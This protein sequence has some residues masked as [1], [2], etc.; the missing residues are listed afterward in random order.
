MGALDDLM[1]LT[2]TKPVANAGTPT[3]DPKE[4][5][6]QMFIQAEKDA[7]TQ[8]VKEDRGFFDKVLD[9]WASLFDAAA[10]KVER[11]FQN[12][13]EDMGI[14]DWKK[15]QAFQDDVATNPRYSQE[16][17]QRKEQDL[18]RSGVINDEYYA[19]IRR[20][21]NTLLNAE[22]PD[23]VLEGK[24]RKD[25]TA[26]LSI[27]Y[28]QTQDPNVVRILNQ[29]I[30]TQTDT[31]MNYYR[32]IAES[33]D[34]LEKTLLFQELSAFMEKG[35]T[36]MREYADNVVKT[37]DNV[38]AYNT[39]A[40][41]HEEFLRDMDAWN[42]KLTTSSRWAGVKWSV[43]GLFDSDFNLADDIG[44]IWWAGTGLISMATGLIGGLAHQTKRNVFGSYN[45]GMEELRLDYIEKPTD[46][47]TTTLAGKMG[48]WIGEIWD[49][50]DTLL[51][52]VIPIFAASKIW[53]LTKTENAA[54]LIEGTSKASKALGYTKYF[55]T[56]M[57][58]DAVIFDNAFQ[59]FQKRGT[60]QDE[61]TTNFWTNAVFNAGIAVV[62]GK[63]V[64]KMA[65]EYEAILKT[66]QYDAR[67][68]G[69][70]D[71]IVR[72][73]NAGEVNFAENTIYGTIKDMSEGIEPVKATITLTSKWKENYEKIL[74]SA[75]RTLANLQKGVLTD[76]GFAAQ[77]IIQQA[78]DP[79]TRK[80]KQSEDILEARKYLTEQTVKEVTVNKATNGIKSLAQMKNTP[81]TE[82]LLRQALWLL[83]ESAKALDN[84]P[85]AFTKQVEESILTKIKNMKGGDSS[86]SF[87][88]VEEIYAARLG[89][90]LVDVI[91]VTDSNTVASAFWKDIIPI[92]QI[93]PSIPYKTLMSY[94]EL[95]QKISFEPIQSTYKEFMD[96][97]FKK[98][99][100]VRLNTLLPGWETYDFMSWFTTRLIKTFGNKDTGEINMAR[101]AESVRN[102]NGRQ[103]GFTAADLDALKL[104]HLPMLFEHFQK[105]KLAN[106]SRDVSDEK[107]FTSHPFFRLFEKTDDGTFNAKVNIADYRDIETALGV[108]FQKMTRADIKDLSAMKYVL[109]DEKFKDGIIKFFAEVAWAIA[110][111]DRKH[112]W[113][114]SQ[115]LFIDPIK[116][117]Q[118]E[119]LYI[120]N[121]EDG[122][123]ILKMYV[124]KIIKKVPQLE[125]AYY[126]TWLR[127]LPERPFAMQKDYT[128]YAREFS[129]HIDE[130]LKSAEVPLSAD[131]IKVKNNL[132]AKAMD[133]IV[134][135]N[136]IDYETALHA[137]HRSAISSDVKRF[138]ELLLKLELALP[139]ERVTLQ[140]EVDILKKSIR[141][142]SKLV[143]GKWV[144]RDNVRL[145]LD[146]LRSNPAKHTAVFADIVKSEDVA[147]SIRAILSSTDALS[148]ENAR[149]NLRIALMSTDLNHNDFVNIQELL[150][151]PK[152]I[153]GDRV[154]YLK[155]IQK[156]QDGNLE[157]AVMYKDVLLSNYLSAGV[158]AIEEASAIV[159]ALPKKETLNLI[160]K[161]KQAK[162]FADSKR[163]KAERAMPKA[164]PESSTQLDA[165]YKSQPGLFSKE[166]LSDIESIPAKSII[167]VGRESDDSIDLIRKQKI[168]GSSDTSFK[169]LFDLKVMF[170]EAESRYGARSGNRTKIN[171]YYKKFVER[172]GRIY[173]TDNALKSYAETLARKP[174][175]VAKDTEWL[176]KAM[177]NIRVD[178]HPLL[179]RLPGSIHLSKNKEGVSLALT[180]IESV[181]I[182]KTLE[183]TNIISDDSKK[184]LSGLIP[185]MQKHLGLESIQFPI[186]ALRAKNILEEVFEGTNLWTMF[187]SMSK[188][189]NKLKGQ[190][191]DIMKY[192]KGPDFK[193]AYSE[194]VRKTTALINK[195]GA[196]LLKDAPWVT[197]SFLLSEQEYLDMSRV[198]LLSKDLNISRAQ[199]Y[200]HFA[201]RITDNFLKKLDDKNLDA[202]RYAT[203]F[204]LKALRDLHYT[205]PD[206]DGRE[207]SSIV[208]ELAVDTVG[209]I[210]DVARHLIN[211]SRLIGELETGRGIQTWV[212]HI[213]DSLKKDPRIGQEYDRWGLEFDKDIAKVA[214]P[215]DDIKTISNIETADDN[216]DILKQFAEA[217]DE[218]KYSEEAQMNIL[219]A[220]QKAVREGNKQLVAEIEAKYP[221]IFQRSVKDEPLDIANMSPEDLATLRKN[222]PDPIWTEAAVFTDYAPQKL[223]A[224]P[225]EELFEYIGGAFRK[226][227]KTIAGDLYGSRFFTPYMNIS[228]EVSPDDAIY[229]A[230]SKTSSYKPENKFFANPSQYIEDFEWLSTAIKHN[231][232]FVYD[233]KGIK[234]IASK[235]Q[236]QDTIMWALYRAMKN[237]ES[238]K[239]AFNF[240]IVPKW[241]KIKLNDAGTGFKSVDGQTYIDV[242]EQLSLAAFKN[243]LA[244]F[245]KHPLFK[246]AF[247]DQIS[248]RKSV[249]GIV[250]EWAS[251]KGEQSIKMPLKDEPL[252][253]A[254]VKKIDTVKALAKAAISNK[255][256]WFGE[257]STGLY[258]QQ[259]GKALS[260]TG[261]YTKDDVVFVSVNGSPTPQN[262]ES[263]LAE[264]KKALSAGAT[265]VMD[266]KRYLKGS[267][268]NHW[269]REVHEYLSSLGIRYADFDYNGTTVW[270]WNAQARATPKKFKE[271][272][273]R[274]PKEALDTYLRTG[275]L[276]KAT[277]F[278]AALH[279][280]RL[281]LR[282]FES[283]FNLQKSNDYLGSDMF[284][285]T[286]TEESQRTL[287]EKLS[288]VITLDK[289]D[290]IMTVEVLWYKP[291][292]VITD[293]DT[294]EYLAT[295]VADEYLRNGEQDLRSL[296]E[297]FT[298]DKLQ[299]SY[300]EE[301]IL[302]DLI[303]QGDFRITTFNGK[304]I[305]YGQFDDIRNAPPK[306]YTGPITL[307]LRTAQERKEILSSYEQLTGDGWTED[308]VFKLLSARD[309]ILKEDMVSMRSVVEEVEE[310]KQDM[311]DIVAENIQKEFW[312]DTPLKWYQRLANSIQIN[313]K[314]DYEKASRDGWY[315]SAEWL[316]ARLR[317]WINKNGKVIAGKGQGAK[318]MADFEKVGTSLLFKKVPD[319][320]IAQDTGVD[321]MAYARY[322]NKSD[323][324]W[325]V[326]SAFKQKMGSEVAFN[327]EIMTDI[328]KKTVDDPKIQT[329]LI[330]DMSSLS[331]TY[332]AKINRGNYTQTIAFAKG[333]DRAVINRFLAYMQ[334]Q[335][336]LNSWMYYLAKATDK[337]L[338]IQKTMTHVNYFGFLDMIYKSGQEDYIIEALK[339]M[340]LDPTIKNIVEYFVD[341]HVRSSFPQLTPDK[342]L[343]LRNLFLLKDPKNPYMDGD[344]IL[345][346]RKVEGW[347]KA[348]GSFLVRETRML[349]TASKFAPFVTGSWL[350]WG[351]NLF[352][353]IMQAR[354]M[355]TWLPEA[356]FKHDL[357]DYM[358]DTGFLDGMADYENIRSLLMG[359]GK[360]TL[361]EK[362]FD[363]VIGKP[364]YTIAG[365]IPTDIWKA[366]ANKSVQVVHDVV[367]T[368]AHNAQ[369]HIMAPM[370][371]RLGITQAA[372]EVF[373][374][375]FDDALKAL[376]AGQMSKAK[377]DRF[378]IRAKELAESGNNAYSSDVLRKHI[379]STGN[380]A[381]V[382]YLQ[383][384]HIQRL[385]ELTSSLKKL[386]DAYAGWEI[387]DFQTFKLH[388]WERN[389]E[390]RK[391]LW[392]TI[393]TIHMAF[394]IDHY[395]DSEQNNSELDY[396]KLF[397]EYLSSFSAS[398]FGRMFTNLLAG[399]NDVQAYEDVTGNP[400]GMV[401]G[402]S[403]QALNFIDSIPA[404]L[405]RE[406]DV[407]KIVPRM[408]KAW[409]DGD[410]ALTVALRKEALD[411]MF[412]GNSRFNMPEGA[413]PMGLIAIAEND[414][415]IGSL[416][417]WM[418]KTNQSIYMADK[419]YSAGKVDEFINGKDEDDDEDGWLM[420][421]IKM[422]PF[423]DIVAPKAFSTTAQWKW[424]QALKTT[425]PVFIE[426]YNGWSNVWAKYIQH[427]EGDNEAYRKQTK[428]FFND[429]TAF[430]YS[431]WSKSDHSLEKEKFYTSDSFDMEAR[432]K[433][434]T[435]LLTREIGAEA[436]AE[437]EEQAKKA[438]GEPSVTDELMVWEK[439]LGDRMWNE[440]RTAS[441]EEAGF[442]KLLAQIES[443]TPGT[444]RVVISYLANKDF[445][446]WSKDFWPRG[447][448]GYLDSKQTD[449]DM[450]SAV[451]KSKIL[452]RYHKYLA[453]A[454]KPSYIKVLSSHVKNAY[455]DVYKDL[456]TSQR[457]MVNALSLVDWVAHTQAISGTPNAGLIANVLSMAGKYIKDPIDRLAVIKNTAQSIMQMDVPQD[458]KDTVL[459]G[460]FVWNTETLYAVSKDP[461]M[462]EQYPTVINGVNNLL[463]GV[464]DKFMLEGK[465]IH[466]MV[467]ADMD[468]KQKKAYYKQATGRAYAYKPY[469]K[470]NSQI[471]DKLIDGA[472]KGGLDWARSAY[473]PRNFDPQTNYNRN[474]EFFAMSHAQRYALP[475]PAVLDTYFKLSRSGDA[476]ALT[477]KELVRQTVKRSPLG[478]RNEYAKPRETSYVK[479]IFPAKPSVKW[480][481]APRIKKRG[482]HTD[483][484]GGLPNVG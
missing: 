314:A 7:D 321:L 447:M 144:Q 26:Q 327:R 80:T 88:P 8:A 383:G 103:T 374:D 72:A 372:F 71:D 146:S 116:M 415:I 482:P 472:E 182:L 367:L 438:F 394:Y 218:S 275:E 411:Q 444:S 344:H 242:D 186:P 279:Q 359:S 477:S 261:T 141:D 329:A 276:P 355:K 13:D 77:R 375:N 78:L 413:N 4:D 15:Y 25:L 191:I 122:A 461:E 221:E 142:K 335:W 97:S 289:N 260:N 245:E 266:S 340:Q 24:I 350:L 464:V 159:D 124:E 17:I 111:T 112:L 332:F 113:D 244:N 255:Y 176:L 430:D 219:S 41:N 451:E 55:W 29:A 484:P 453:I 165:L 268:Y 229:T 381:A 215:S 233:G 155:A 40:Q 427:F 54:R 448:N 303:E 139:A 456:W 298:K 364:A 89:E 400:I 203:Y 9:V 169:T 74:A 463:Y 475:R 35:K 285:K 50:A 106:L 382:S 256:I 208:S 5:Y 391:A 160:H 295:R 384:Y 154:V 481:R 291:T 401:N 156:L 197:K 358:L 443:K 59:T 132:L 462:V 302:D 351:Q 42:S 20:Q 67:W 204:I 43:A 397:N 216:S 283:F 120:T 346:E 326:L 324:F 34:A 84:T 79:A 70:T 264:I 137:Y 423:I 317:S 353:N 235:E 405:F 293:P 337:H 445:Y 210:A 457:T 123:L 158:K 87:T 378:I 247:Q 172:H 109:K 220:R 388:L 205:V 91:K 140:R 292:V 23:N 125:W 93:I 365:W 73:A 299:G 37:K 240:Y 257:W 319:P 446:N 306:A 422:L 196:D 406:F 343:K 271:Q 412:N 356:Y 392:V 92:A 62:L 228:K 153:L 478:E 231:D 290:S 469:M 39:T 53:L 12:E 404:M 476:S 390:L 262:L 442:Q 348:V 238:S 136:Q 46:S 38:A 60:N 387:T 313:N 301:T 94:E 483:L 119:N 163:I 104:L 152:D 195:R 284:A 426:F 459:S 480:M 399:N 86:P 252:P 376:V 14:T 263:T 439:I 105:L 473:R 408:Q 65:N 305:E 278:D 45:S 171:E 396:A 258:R 21:R 98:T 161:Q 354:G 227:L 281:V 200:K 419:L 213:E 352:T 370:H 217:L 460:L 31:Y 114:L 452:S 265:L 393:D 403:V 82:W 380:W 30:D 162:L 455:P 36:F 267:K 183:K 16:E 331:E 385:G 184:T 300:R 253:V 398:F 234:S 274:N 49:G 47:W 63:P 115:Q 198:Y 190:S 339:S 308:E 187:S 402:I 225:I 209:R 315:S 416:L 149:N 64:L 368:G 11:F 201:A 259:I 241:S 170:D 474:P 377:L 151:L 254:P 310:F 379:L 428:D 121:K 349:S 420:R 134:M 100:N 157:E 468:S 110:P 286:E 316:V 424:L 466:A 330:D 435:T 193:Q 407:Y 318:I 27:A 18:Y 414:D 52:A 178:G 342:Q 230:F 322:F 168:E 294:G 126:A 373:G 28:T 181:D 450:A 361:V 3:P 99:G 174:E 389:P 362:L 417:L 345:Q 357:I 347:L 454:D 188:H 85:T 189:F 434:F 328:I 334:E 90:Y 44:N 441:N 145:V 167:I 10:T 95:A 135:L 270:V 147:D 211:E 236:A 479:R 194:Y 363:K 471:Q 421:T 131:L 81:A 69:L 212:T 312:V 166:I 449:W 369:D 437:L 333:E 273:A 323:E 117:K 467:E 223:E 282:E 118:I 206:I 76:D 248:K 237:P 75:N 138:D 148:F 325:S 336:N 48:Q 288:E 320:T 83:R 56:Q 250:E 251:Q 465:S 239:P 22:T 127:K 360:K 431:Q 96:N 458:T 409:Q 133:E 130:S 202:Q 32:R 297:L 6:G 296:G 338:Y 207:L 173:I 61:R 410:V 429:L 232:F 66:I 1:K 107:L 150:L 433:L 180:G 432:E 108:L 143:T 371:A 68:I 425:D 224:A 192:A 269:E 101:L 185:E 440:D 58:Q 33:D 199:T 2:G 177:Q 164:V 304:V 249:M 287:A 226:Q 129:E 175:A 243:G 57:L 386:A 366:V 246:W 222:T 280:R 309:G 102:L 395:Y 311:D 51:E 277:L 214:E 341:W 19:N 436:L 128:S 179:I 470:T 307:D 272:F 418:R